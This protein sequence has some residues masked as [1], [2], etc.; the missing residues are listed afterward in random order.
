MIIKRTVSHHN[1][2]DMA[3]HQNRLKRGLRVLGTYNG[4]VTRNTP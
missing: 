1:I 4:D 2:F 3:E